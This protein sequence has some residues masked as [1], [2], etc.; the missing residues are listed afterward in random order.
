MK[1]LFYVRYSGSHSGGFALVFADN[2]EHAKMLVKND[3]ATENFT[4]VFVSECRT[5]GVVYNDS[6]DY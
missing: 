6:G 5:D 4:D 3:E 1:K 2:A